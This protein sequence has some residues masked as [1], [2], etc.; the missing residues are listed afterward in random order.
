MQHIITIVAISVKRNINDKT[1][2]C[3]IAMLMQK[4]PLINARHGISIFLINVEA[5]RKRKLIF[6]K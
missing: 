4:P 5:E 1:N 2:N 3:N 6:V